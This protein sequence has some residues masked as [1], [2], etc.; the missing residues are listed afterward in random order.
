[1]VSVP[2]HNLTL[3]PSSR[4]FSLSLFSLF[5]SLS[6][7]LP[8]SLGICL[9]IFQFSFFSFLSRHFPCHSLLSPHSLSPPIFLFFCLF[10]L[11]KPSPSSLSLSLSLSLSSSL[12]LSL[13]LLS[14]QRALHAH[15]SMVLPGPHHSRP[16]TRPSR[17]AASISRLKLPANISLGCTRMIAND[18]SELTGA[19]SSNG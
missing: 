5:L 17:L 16:V 10:F 6:L 13:S 9:S 3:A 14:R 11:V 1:M 8:L 12:S 19:F 15:V 18:V 2:Q 7:S 4:S